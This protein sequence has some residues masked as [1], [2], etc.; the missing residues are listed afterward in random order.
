MVMINTDDDE[1]CRAVVDAVPI[2]LFIL[3]DGEDIAGASRK[4]IAI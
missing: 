3:S 1:D 2:M 4:S